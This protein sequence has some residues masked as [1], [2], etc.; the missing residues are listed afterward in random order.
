MDELDLVLEDVDE[1][2]DGLLLLNLICIGLGFL[3]SCPIEG[4]I[5]DRGGMIRDSKLTRLL[6]KPG[7]SMM[8]K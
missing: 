2:L 4:V 7:V 6:P 3:V 5:L 1:A 8:V